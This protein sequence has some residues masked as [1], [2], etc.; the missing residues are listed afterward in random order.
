MPT[1]LNKRE[2]ADE[3]YKIWFSRL[4]TFGLKQAKKI[5]YTAYKELRRQDDERKKKVR[6]KNGNN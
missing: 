1:K 4:C 6:T 2:F 5:V 3:V